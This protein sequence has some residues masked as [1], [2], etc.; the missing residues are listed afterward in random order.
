MVGFRN[1]SVTLAQKGLP[2]TS[3]ILVTASHDVASPHGPAHGRGDLS[4]VTSR[5][6]T[7]SH[8]SCG[9]AERLAHMR[10]SLEAAAT[11]CAV[12]H[13]CRALGSGSEFRNA[14]CLLS[15]SPHSRGPGGS[16]HIHREMDMVL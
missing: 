12:R 14:R 13:L 2:F 3:Q 15:Y 1:A 4:F 7:G 10:T 5:S 8:V 6:V 9:L 16:K 11:V